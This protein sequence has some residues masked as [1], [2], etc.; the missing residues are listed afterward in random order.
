MKQRLLFCRSVLVLTAL[1][2]LV[3]CGAVRLTYNNADILARFKASDYVD[4]T[5]TQSEQFKLRFAALHRWHRI[6]E[7][8]KYVLLLQDAGDRISRGISADDVNWAIA[9]LCAQY[10]LVAARAAEEATPVLAGLT[11]DQLTELEKNFAKSNRKFEKDNLIGDAQRLRRKRAAKIESNI[12]DWTGP[13]NGQQ[14]ARIDGLIDFYARVLVLRLEDRKHWQQEAMAL[15]RARHT[16]SQLAPRLAALYSR[17]EEGR[18]AEYQAA[19]GRYEAAIGELVVDIDRMLSPGQ[20]SR[21]VRRMQAY[22]EDLMAL[23][24]QK[25]ALA[26]P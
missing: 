19:M 24:G 22:T 14:Q 18:S 12:E 17:P 5:A 7:L 3:S 25:T 15:L 8:P 26:A 11:P 2:A 21:A 16:P 20:R 10:R 13:L 1:L 9:A 4:L 6:S 23:A